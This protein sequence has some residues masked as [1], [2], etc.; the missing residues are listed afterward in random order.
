MHPPT[1]PPRPR[2]RG[3]WR[4]LCIGPSVVTTS[5]GRRPTTPTPSRMAAPGARA[6]MASAREGER[7]HA[8]VGQPD[9][10]QRRPGGTG[11]QRA[12][13]P[14]R[15]G[16]PG[17][18][19]HA[20]TPPCAATPPR[21]PLRAPG[22]G[23]LQGPCLR[24]PPSPRGDPGPDP[25]TCH[26]RSRPGRAAGP[27][28]RPRFG[29]PAC[30]PRRRSHRIPRVPLQEDRAGSPPG[31]L[32]GDGAADDA[33]T[34]SFTAHLDSA[35]LHA[36]GTDPLPRSAPAGRGMRC[37]AASSNAQN[38]F[39]GT[40]PPGDTAQSPGRAGVAACRQGPSG[41]WRIDR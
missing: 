17:D 36:A 34:M 40:G 29:V 2:Q 20:A 26:E 12:P 33:V 13:R 9:R 24:A 16:A 3:R 39:E 11:S 22:G 41:P 31:A 19:G 15:T 32:V 7:A 6:A 28:A 21:S 38:D 4:G 14:H 1:A 10:P 37:V 23:C 18:P 30:P 5:R 35:G 27:G 25:R 8:A